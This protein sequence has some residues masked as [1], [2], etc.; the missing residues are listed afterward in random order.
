[1]YMKKKLLNLLLLMV[2]PLAMQAQSVTVGKLLYT[3]INDSTCYVEIANKNEA[4]TDTLVVLPSEVEIEETSHRV[5]QVRMRGF[6]LGEKANALKKIV[7]PETMERIGAYSFMG[8]ALETLTIPDNVTFIGNYAFS[9]SQKMTAV[10]LGKSVNKIGYSAFEGANNIQV[11]TLHATTP[12]TLTNQPFTCTSKAKLVVPIGTKSVYEQIDYWKEFKNIEEEELQS[13]I[14]AD[15][16]D[17]L[18][19][20]VASCKNWLPK[21]D[22]DNMEYQAFHTYPIAEDGLSTRYGDY[23]GGNL[24]G[25]WGAPVGNKYYLTA[26]NQDKYNEFSLITL[27]AATFE[28]LDKEDISD[29]KD[30]IANDAALDPTTGK[31]YGVFIEPETHTYVFGTV[32]PVTKERTAIAPYSKGDNTPSAF[33]VSPEGELYGILYYGELV[34]FDKETGEITEI[35]NTGVVWS[36]VQAA[37][38]SLKDNMIHASWAGNGG[39]PS[40]FTINP[41]TAEM[42]QLSPETTLMTIFYNPCLYV[43]AKAPANVMAEN[44]TFEKYSENGILSFTAPKTFHDGSVLSGS[45]NYYIT[46]KGEIISQGTTTAGERVSVNVTGSGVTKF[47]I[48]TENENGES[49]RRIVSGYAGSDV[50]ATPLVSAKKGENSIKITWNPIK[51]GEH[52]GYIDT[53]NVKYDVYK[54]PGGEKIATDLVVNEYTDNTLEEELK[55]KVVNYNYAVV[56]KVD[57]KESAQGVS[58]KIAWGYYEP[59]WTNSLSGES[60]FK[61]FTVIDANKDGQTWDF[62]G[63][64]TLCFYN[65]TQPKDDWLISPPMHM[66][67][68]LIYRLNYNAC[69]NGREYTNKYEIY[70]GQDNTVAAMNTKVQDEIS[71]TSLAY[72]QYKDNDFKSFSNDVTV[73]EDGDYYFGWH[74]TSEKEQGYLV[75]KNVEVL[76]G[77]EAVSPKQVSNCSVVADENGRFLTNISF[78]MPVAKNNG[79]T[80]SGNVKAEIKRNGIVVKTLAAM[81]GDKIEYVDSAEEAGNYVY[82]ITPISADGR[83]MEY[84]KKVFVGN[85]I[86]Y[87]TY[88]FTAKEN[89]NKY[90][91]VTLSW[92]LPS[93][94][95]NFRQLDP[96]KMRYIITYSTDEGETIDTLLNDYKGFSYT[97]QAVKEG[98]GQKNIIYYIKG[99]NYAGS[100]SDTPSCQV[101]AGEPNATPWAE[102]FLDEMSVPY[103]MNSG[104]QRWKDAVDGSITSQD[105]DGQ[106]AGYKGTNVGDTGDMI[107]GK[108]DMKGLSS[109]KL[110]FWIYKFIDEDV[111]T[112]ETFVGSTDN[113]NSLGTVDL[114]NYGTGWNKVSFDISQYNGEVVQ[115]RFLAKANYVIYVLVDN[116]LLASDGWTPDSVGEVNAC[117]DVVNVKYFDISGRMVAKPKRGSLVVRQIK[118]SDGK[119]K[120]DKM[121]VE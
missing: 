84:L 62:I 13:E 29:R 112:L 8:T 7:F 63:N 113:W 79:A 116:M 104:W 86:P 98:E 100:M 52:G 115:L 64:S 30:L 88:D 12:P 55:N 95:M 20:Y 10:I 41:Q 82:T 83:G 18:L 66:K 31:I 75:I 22:Y 60:S 108:L 48:Y 107:T 14:V 68:G 71:I 80:L 102:S 34:K 92:G 111:N 87:P 47:G 99:Y 1:M 2:I 117:D 38:W 3:A 103:I 89:V 69:T 6:S 94:D 36:Y 119:V 74:A 16:Q 32:N 4:F 27:D 35:G 33:C 40:V 85:S 51:I 118:T 73:D 93:Y 114:Q 106:F 15:S 21:D 70:I 23:I 37:S 110:T 72:P 121:V 9:D 25:L 90:G 53:L 97:Y 54:F 44:L 28:L 42:T 61:E 91:E 46:N 109:P 17:S 43:K 56:A 39:M 78:T 101:L 57:E 65:T 67:K 96:E 59:T 76:T 77:V 58:N 45:L 81:A 105:G 49:L 120:T 24:A 26:T 19:I 50:P 5:T 11:V